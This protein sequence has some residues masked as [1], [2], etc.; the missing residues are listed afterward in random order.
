VYSLME[1]SVDI[2]ATDILGLRKGYRNDV[3]RTPLGGIDATASNEFSFGGSVKGYN[4]NEDQDDV[5]R[6]PLGG[7]DPTAP[8]AFSFADS[9]KRA[10]AG[11]KGGLGQDNVSS[12][13]H[14][15]HDTTTS[16]GLSSASVD[17][18]DEKD[19][20]DIPRTP[21]GGH[22]PTA[23]N[24]FSFADSLKRGEAGKGVGQVDGSELQGGSQSGDEQ[25]LPDTTSGMGGGVGDK[26]N[27]DS[28]PTTPFGG[29]DPTAPNA[30]SF[31]DAVMEN[32]QDTQT[33]GQ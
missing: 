20:E 23:P 6:T 26:K 15:N 28:V 17:D 33:N 14:D 24:A 1:E 16:N 27:F 21:F 18:G 29:H 12:N 32:S 5:P 30:F 31:A 8:N 9:V 7:H 11:K 4:P 3:P 10:D 19:D 2:E 22:D 13:P 25:T